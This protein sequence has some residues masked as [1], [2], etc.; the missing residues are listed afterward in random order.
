M[1]RGGAMNEYFVI[2]SEFETRE[3]C[4]K[5]ITKERFKWAKGLKEAREISPVN[6]HY[7][8]N[9]GSWYGFWYD[10]IKGNGIECIALK[11]C[12]K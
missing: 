2:I 9:T 10:I 4:S 6:L 7:S 12:K 11:R 8:R 1:L 5:H 3:D